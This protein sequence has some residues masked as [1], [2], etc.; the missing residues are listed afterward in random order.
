MNFSNAIKQVFYQA[1]STATD[2]AYIPILDAQGNPVGAISKENLLA[3]I[4]GQ[5]PVQEEEQVP[6]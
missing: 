1:G 4:Q 6:E 5:V 2:F 3:L